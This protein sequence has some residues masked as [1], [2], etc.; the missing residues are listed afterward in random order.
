MKRLTEWDN[1]RILAMFGV[2]LFHCTMYFNPWGWH[3][4][5]GITSDAVIPFSLL[6]SNWIMPV[7][8][9]LSGVGTYYSRQLRGNGAFLRER[10][11]RLGVPLLLG[12]FVLSPPQVYIERITNGLTGDFHYFDGW[13]GFGGNFAWMGLHLWYL[14]FLLLFSALTL[15]FL[16]KGTWDVPAW[17]LL[18]L[19]VPIALGDLITGDTIGTRQMGSW[20][21]P[22][23]LVWYLLG[24]Y[25]FTAE[26]IR[27]A[28]LRYGP[29]LAVLAAITFFMPVRALHSYFFVLAMLW[30]GLRFFSKSSSPFWNAALMPFYVLHQPVIVIL[31]Y[32]LREW[33]VPILLK[34]PVLAGS[35][36]A[37]IMSIYWA[38]I[39][40]FP[41]VAFWFG[42]KKRPSAR[43][44]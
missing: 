12:M 5:N 11:L 21:L 19:W 28:L 9:V 29:V 40:P 44:S 8:F 1:V 41:A 25:V 31:G 22:T 34:Y 42:V 4:K 33:D 20:N 15:P 7:F 43:M 14:L 26:A 39:R 18:L 17:S 2:F 37:I 13:Y 30:L 16:K 10:L 38:V 27:K 35:A 24:Y 23:Y 32:F 3:V 36:F 6:F